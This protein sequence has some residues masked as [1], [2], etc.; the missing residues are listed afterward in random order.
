LIDARNEAEAVINATEKSL[1]RP[2]FA[3]LVAGDLEAGELDRIRAA[4]A[5][6]R[7]AMAG[8]DRD[9]IQQRTHDLNHATR[10]LAELM[11]NRSVREALTGKNVHDV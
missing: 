8:T 4:I 3:E 9:A 6:T 2:D 10:H 7:E 5:A 11:M 1:R